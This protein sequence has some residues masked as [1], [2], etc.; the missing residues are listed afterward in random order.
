MA[1]KALNTKDE[2]TSFRKTLLYA[3]HGW[4]KTTQAVHYKRRY[5]KGF[6]ISGEAG[7]S[8]VRSEGI[9]YLPF[10]SFDGKHSY[11]EGV[12]SFK[13]ICKDMM[14]EDFKKQGYK[15]IMLD[16]L[17]ELGDMVLAHVKADIESSG[18]KNNGFQVWGDYASLMIG[19]CKWIRD[20]PYHVV[21]SA[22]AKEQTDDNNAT[23]Y[24]PMVQGNAVQKQ[25]PGIFDCVMC[26][27]KTTKQNTDGTI[28]VER[29]IVTDEVRG[30]H[31]KVRDE[32][33]R[34]KSV[35]R[36]HDLTNLFAIMEMTDEAY[37]KYAKETNR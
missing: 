33:R 4:G 30:W 2:S 26:G 34:V 5:G 32:K 37:D 35:E 28:S 21:V 23:D 22:L 16:S 19:A 29:F 8:S 13:G 25:L 11:D 9:D 6:I 12:F 31:G 27:V 36:E 14:S 15:W 18:G 7:L 24:W 20:L 17:T 1:F 10:S 3:H